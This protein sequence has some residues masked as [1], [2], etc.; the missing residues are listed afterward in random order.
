MTTAELTLYKGYTIAIDYDSDPSNPR[1]WD[2]FGTM[3]CFHRRYALGDS[4]KLDIDD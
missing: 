2:N 3:V 1:E 4:F